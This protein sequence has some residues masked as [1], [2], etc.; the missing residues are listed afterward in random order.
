[1]VIRLIAIA[2]FILSLVTP[3]AAQKYEGDYLYHVMT[4]RADIG[5]L[6]PLLDWLSALK[7]SDYFD[8]AGLATPFVVRHS[9]GDQWD[10]MAIAPMGSWTKFHS[11]ANTKKRDAAREKYSETLGNGASLIA[12]S[13]DHFAFGPPFEDFEALVEGKGLFHIEMFEAA[14]GKAGDLLEQRRMENA[15]LGATGQTQNMIFRRAAGSNVDVFTIGAHDSLEAFAAPSS[16][17]NDE[18]EA[19]AIAAGFKDRADL[20]FYL[21]A[22]ISGHHDTLANKVN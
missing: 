5:K 20:S 11:T 22:L 10:L 9:Q 14:A 3:A 18:K 7:A 19:A 2:A 1:M 13:E 16:A 8:A 21:R 6:E 4:V 15:Y 17:S 12:F